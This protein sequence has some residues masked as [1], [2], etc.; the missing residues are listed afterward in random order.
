MTALHRRWLE[1]GDVTAREKITV[2]NLRR[3]LSTALVAARASGLHRQRAGLRLA[4]AA[5]PAG[6]PRG[7]R[8]GGDEDFLRS[9]GWAL[10]TRCATAATGSTRIK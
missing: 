2:L 3:A 9:V 1:L 5:D 7:R 6:Q 10:T 8:A 4:G